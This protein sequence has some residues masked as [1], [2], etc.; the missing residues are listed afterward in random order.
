MEVCWQ[1][2]PECYRGSPIFL[3]NVWP[4]PEADA[5]FRCWLR[6]VHNDGHILPQ[7]ANRWPDPALGE[8]F[9]AREFEIQ[10]YQQTSS[11]VGK[12]RLHHNFTRIR[13]LN[14]TWTS[15]LVI[16]GTDS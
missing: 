15:A 13:R 8:S 6:A 4:A 12:L 16:R 7:L 14:P 11:R 2:Y 10:V 3:L 9:A 5:N 1:A